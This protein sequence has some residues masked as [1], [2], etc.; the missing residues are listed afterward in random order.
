MRALLDR[1]GVEEH[2]QPSARDGLVLFARQLMEEGDGLIVG[3]A[4]VRA[5]IGEK[6]LM[7]T[8]LV[9]KWLPNLHWSFV[10]LQAGSYKYWFAGSQPHRTD[11]PVGIMRASILERSHA[12]GPL[13][14]VVAQ[15]RT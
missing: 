3:L 1:L 15:A 2:F 11:R 7:G 10:R 6:D 12:N 13:Q 8:W 9:I 14:A 5:G 4:V